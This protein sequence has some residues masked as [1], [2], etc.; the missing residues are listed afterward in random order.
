MLSVE[1][2][3]P[4]WCVCVCVCV[5]VSLSQLIEGSR[6]KE[7]ER[8]RLLGLSI[9]IHVPL[10][11]AETIQGECGGPRPEMKSPRRLF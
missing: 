7:K 2:V 4:V 8:E 11:S 9:G 1:E 6:G 3:Y 5:C 10:R